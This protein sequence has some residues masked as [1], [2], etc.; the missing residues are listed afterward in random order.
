M[1]DTTIWSQAL[2]QLPA[3]AMSL[4]A[5]MFMIVKGMH[6]FTSMSASFMRHQEERDKTFIAGMNEIGEECHRWGERREEAM[7][8]T[9]QGHREV[10]S[11][12]E[13]AVVRLAA[14]LEQR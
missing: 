11:K 12:Q 13:E 1:Q 14:A 9:M 6:F 3:L 4:A 2:E 10:M 8:R 7:L 5:F